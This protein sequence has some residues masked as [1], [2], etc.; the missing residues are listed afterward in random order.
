MLLYMCSIN[1]MVF[2]KSESPFYYFVLD[3]YEL[4]I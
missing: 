4:H 3:I 2:N 1:P